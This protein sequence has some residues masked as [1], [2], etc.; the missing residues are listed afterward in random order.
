M[1]KYF[2]NWDNEIHCAAMHETRVRQ[3]WSGSSCINKCHNKCP[4]ALWLIIT[5]F[6]LI[7]AFFTSNKI[8]RRFKTWPLSTSKLIRLFSGSCRSSQSGPFHAK[9]R[10]FNYS[11]SQNC[12]DTTFSLSSQCW[13]K[14]FAKLTAT[15]EIGRER[16]RARTEK[17]AFE[18][19]CPNYFSRNL[20]YTE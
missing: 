18:W 10:R 17:T 11:L 13:G 7:D 20:W 9:F 6:W 1:N 15:N 16:R 4:Y 14:R 2:E 19:K 5:L 12:W 8:S 3:Q